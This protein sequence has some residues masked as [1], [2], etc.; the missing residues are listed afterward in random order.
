VLLKAMQRLAEDGAHQRSM[1][2]DVRPE[3]TASAAPRL[4]VH[5]ANLDLSPGTFQNEIRSLLE[6][7]RQNVTLIGQYAH[8]DLPQLM[9]NIDWVIVPSIWWENSPLVIQEAFAYG[10]PILCSNIGGMAEKVTHRV[11]GLHFR[12]GDTAHLAQTI[13]EAANTPGLWDDLRRGIPPLYPMQQHVES[14]TGVY[15]QLFER[16]NADRHQP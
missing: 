11:N 4:W 5:G 9:H 14:I 12:V 13:R 3:D 8:D 2:P 16:K 1:P 15:R 6:A 7:T 10:K